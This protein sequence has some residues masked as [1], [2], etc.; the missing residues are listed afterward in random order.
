MKYYKLLWAIILIISAQIISYMQVYGQLKWQWSRDN[1]LIML[2]IGLPIGL[3]IM[4]SADIITTITGTVW[5]VRLIGQ[6]LGIITFC[7]MSWVLFKE[8][9]TLK[10]IICI[11]LEIIIICIQL[12]W[13]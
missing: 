5:H 6:A 9:L 2:L 13:K 3:L 11:I 1:K 10:L 12:F 7:I 4:K 8:P